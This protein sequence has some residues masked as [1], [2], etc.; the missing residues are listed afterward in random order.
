M[1]IFTH[2]ADLKQQQ[3]PKTAVALGTFDGVHIGHQ[4]I[5][6]Q[7]VDLA[8]SYGGASVVFTFANHP[9]SVIN[10]RR[11]PPQIVT[12][13]YKAELI[14]SLGVDILLSI[15]F[16][17]EFLQLAPEEFIVLLLSHLHPANLVIGPNYHYGHKGSGTPDTLKTAGFNHG[18]NV[19]VHPAVYVQNIMVS[20]TSIRRFIHEGN[21][22]QA[23]LL[24][25]RPPR[26][27]G[28]VVSGDGRGKMLGYPTANIAIDN[29]L[30]IPSNGVYAVKVQI[31]DK[32]YNAVANI[33]I[34]PTFTGQTRRIEVFLLNFEGN[35]YDRIILVDFLAKLRAE[36]TFNSVSELTN[37]IAQDISSAQKYYQ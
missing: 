18:F 4:K 32:R 31:D 14:Q 8:A 35:L 7:A 12:N 1:K 37:Q 34:N 27:G 25:G 22:D 21:I 19:V 13:E 23:T 2:L 16:T 33:G 24:L 3:F 9:L 10:P 20:S 15:P 6:R 29:M 5:I 36:I 30:V 28:M 11:C 17:Q 26:I